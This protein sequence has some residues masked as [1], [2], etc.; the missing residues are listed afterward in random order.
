MK[1]QIMIILVLSSFFTSCKKA[2]L[3]SKNYIEDLK[4]SWYNTTTN[5]DAIIFQNDSTL[6]RKFLTTGVTNN[7][8]SIKLKS[9]EII[10][11]YTGIDK[12]YCPSSSH[13]Y[14]LNK[15]KDTLV[16]ENLSQYYPNYAGNRFCKF[17]NK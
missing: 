11:Q 13:K 8:Y 10:L 5:Y 6:D 16:I 1:T 15:S 17:Q 3:D 12:I 2:G 7:H 4:G 14:Y 9:D